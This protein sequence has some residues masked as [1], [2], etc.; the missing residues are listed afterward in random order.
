LARA[1]PDR[2]RRRKIQ[3]IAGTVGCLGA[4]AGVAAHAAATGFSGAQQA[5]E[6]AVSAGDIY[7]SAPAGNTSGNRLTLAVS[8]LIPNVLRW[9]VANVTNGDSAASGGVDL[10]S[11]TLLTNATLSST[12]NTNALGL[13]YEVQAC[14]SGS[15]GI[16]WT[17]SGTSPDFSYACSNT[18]VNV[19]GG[20]STVQAAPSAGANTPATTLTNLDLTAGHTNYLRFA[21]KLTS[22]APAS[23]EGQT[24]AISFVFDG[25][26][27]SGTNK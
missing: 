26:Q 18:V 12:L 6:G 16:A 3:R 20:G 23:L 11:M 19:L 15:V 4:A 2:E 10:A 14:M 27:R 1:G 25:T 8:D 5:N 7:L 24:S 17:E 21:F 22:A 9:R 13:Y